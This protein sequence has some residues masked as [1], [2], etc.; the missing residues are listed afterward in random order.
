MQEIRQRK[1]NDNLLNAYF[2][3]SLM[4]RIHNWKEER[5]DLTHAMADGTKSIMEIKKSAYLLSMNAKKLV[6]DVCNAAILLKK[7]RHKVSA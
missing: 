4:D 1:Q 7:N 5:N 6:K 2:N 3:D